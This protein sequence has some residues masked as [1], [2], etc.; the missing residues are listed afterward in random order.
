MI[1]SCGACKRGMAT[2]PAVATAAG[3]K[4]ENRRGAGRGK[5]QA[6]AAHLAAVAWTIAAGGG[7]GGDLST[8]LFRVVGP[9]ANNSQQHTQ[10]T[11]SST[12]QDSSSS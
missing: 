2:K 3:G 1:P 7:G 12:R 8:G 9:R 5:V 11:Y 4:G 6:A 10:T